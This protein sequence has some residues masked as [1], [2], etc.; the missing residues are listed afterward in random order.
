MAADGVP[1]SSFLLIGSI[2]LRLIG[3]LAVLLGFYA[4]TG[5]ALLV[6]FV[7][8]AAVLAHDFW[9]MPPGRQKHETIEFL[10][11]LAMAG[12]ALLIVLNGAGSV[13]ID[14]LKAD[15]KRRPLALG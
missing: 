14:S 4:R 11:N 9:T 12:G 15:K 8:P 2:G 3:G 10:N 1:R 5:A 13:S 7:L 6:A